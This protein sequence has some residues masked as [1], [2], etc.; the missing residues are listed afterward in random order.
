MSLQTYK[1]LIVDDDKIIHKITERMLEDSKF[2]DFHIEILTAY[3][4]VEAKEIFK[5]HDDIAMAIIDIQ[6][7]TKYAGL[8]LVNFIRHVLQ[9]DLIRLVIRT[10]LTEKF[11]AIQVTQLYDVNDFIEK[12]N[13]TASRLYA[14]I[15]SCV[16]EYIQLIK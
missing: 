13:F 7:E 4:A 3:S 2:S 8:H 9:N 1:I 11:S 14:A 12:Q 10:S 6:M 15:E 5:Q 16:K